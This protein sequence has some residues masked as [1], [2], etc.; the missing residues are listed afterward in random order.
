MHPHTQAIVA[1][2]AYAFITGRKVAGVH[3]HQSGRDLLIAAEVRAGRLQG[4]DGDR[5]SR[6][7]ATPSEIHDAADNA[8]ISLEIDGD[9]ARGYDR[10]SASHYSLKVTEPIVQLYDHSASAWLAFTIQAA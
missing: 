8:F 2:T 6:F 5:A 10:G 9:D 4:M 7:S 1:A 3:D